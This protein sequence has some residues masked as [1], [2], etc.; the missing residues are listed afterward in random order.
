M[1]NA[2]VKRYLSSPPVW[3]RASVAYCLAL[4]LLLVMEHLTFV[5]AAVPLTIATSNTMLTVSIDGSLL[6]VPVPSSPTQVLFLSGDPAVREF[7]LDGTDSINNFSLDPTYMHRIAKTPYYRFQAWMRNFDTYSSWRDVAVRTSTTGRLVTSVPEADTG[8]LVSLPAGSATVTASIVRLEVPVQIDVICGRRECGAIQ[9]DRNDRFVQV[10]AYLANGD[11]GISQRVFFPNSALPFIADVA[12]LL[13]HVMIWSLLVLGLLVLLHLTLL[14][15]SLGLVGMKGAR[16]VTARLSRR[17]EAL[18]GGVSR[19]RKRVRVLLSSGL[20][21][22]DLAAVVVVLSAFAYTCWIAL[23]QY[24]AEPHILDASAY[25]FQAKIFA[26][27]RLSVAVPGNLGA[28]QGPFMVAD[29]GRWFAQYPPGTSALLALGLLLHL[30]W[31]VEPVLG[32][33]ALW[34]IYQLGRLMF[35]PLV[36]VL[37]ALLG[38]LSAFY[39]YLAASYLSHTIALFFGVYF[40]LSLLRF[41]ERFRVRHLIIAS[42]CAGGLLLT[43]ELSMVLVC[44]GSIA[45]LVVFYRHR[46]WAERYRIA[47]LVVLPAAVLGVCVALYLAYNALQTGSP[48]LLPR[49]VFNPSDRYGFGQGVGFYGQHTL[50]A[51][52]VNLDQLLTILLIDLYGWP[53]YFTLAFIPLAYLRRRRE[54][55]WDFF[56]L[57]MCSLL[58]LAQVGYFYHG[59]YLGPRYLYDSLPFLLLLSARG[60]TALSSALVRLAARMAPTIAG[61]SLRQVAAR[62]LVA[63]LV[64]ALI[65]CNL[66]YYLPRQT[67]LYRNYTGLPVTEPLQVTT[68]YAFHP[69]HAIVLTSDW[70]IYNYVLFPLN[71]PELKGETLYAY[72]PSSSVVSQLE[73]QY[74]DRTLYMLQVGTGGDVTFLPVTR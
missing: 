57:A 61:A 13:I 11:P 46:W 43:R 1:R 41:L 17:L 30:P 10:Q 8:T 23:A 66:F 72:A 4:L 59:I 34:G 20:D 47:A 73:E 67:A 14:A 71:G 37:A 22:W 48:F 49:T 24:H 44:G 29:Q 45:I 26:S 28:F 56:C 16:V 50:A 54:L 63:A 12:N 27:G 70:F 42:L 32:A 39:L 40:L 15:L 38:A 64:L 9:V 69:Q 7:Q 55:E 51:G 58:I 53:F 6:S 60:M 36:A 5:A 62:G 35:S 25:I 18:R 68:I 74:P 52:F 33:L 21:H 19:L 3:A 65:G 2:I 31:L